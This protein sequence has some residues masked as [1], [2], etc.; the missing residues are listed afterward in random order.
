MIDPNLLARIRRA[1]VESN[2]AEAKVRS[3]IRDAVDA[4]ATYAEL[5]KELGVSRQAIRQRVL[6]IAA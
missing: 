2:R 6:R 4:G 1:Q 5:A 3:A